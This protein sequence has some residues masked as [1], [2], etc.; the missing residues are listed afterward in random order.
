V[1]SA[2]GVSENILIRQRKVEFLRGVLRR[3]QDSLSESLLS[4][5]MLE[6]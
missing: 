5:F 1:S 2:V 6:I 3:I 4:V